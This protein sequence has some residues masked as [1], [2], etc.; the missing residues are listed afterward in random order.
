MQ[1]SFLM[2]FIVHLTYT[3]VGIALIFT[4]TQEFFDYAFWAHIPYI[5]VCLLSILQIFKLG[6]KML[7]LFGVL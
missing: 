7:R 3:T 1:F 4:R 5:T 6:K 2:V